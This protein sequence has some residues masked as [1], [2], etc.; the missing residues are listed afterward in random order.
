MIS[1]PL[2]LFGVAR[3]FM[4]AACLLLFGYG[5]TTSAVYRVK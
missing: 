5:A 3:F 4:L 1:S 2:V